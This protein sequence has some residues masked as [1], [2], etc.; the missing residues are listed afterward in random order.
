MTDQER[1]EILASITPSAPRRAFTVGVMGSLGLLLVLLAFLRPPAS[2]PLQIMLI[3]LG[4]VALIG[5]VRMFKATSRGLVLSNADLRDTGGALVASF[6]D[7]EKVERGVFAFK[8]SNGF[9]LR[10]R[11]PMPRAWEPG[12]WWRF[13]RRVGVGGAISGAEGRQMAD[14]IA[15]RLASSERH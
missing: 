2:F 12:L 9:V 10:L 8:P 7:I 13:G 11:S 4:I 1:P 15:A 14:V 5:C 3:L 6:A